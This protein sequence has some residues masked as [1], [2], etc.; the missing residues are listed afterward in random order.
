MK[1]ATEGNSRYI[2]IYIKAYLEFVYASPYVILEVSFGRSYMNQFKVVIC[3]EAHEV[4][5][6]FSA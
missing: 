2:Y 1:Q 3:G 6:M 5:S 4:H